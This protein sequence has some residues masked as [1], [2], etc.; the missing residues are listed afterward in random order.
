MKKLQRQEKDMQCSNCPDREVC[1]NFGS[2]SPSSRDYQQ[3]KQ[4]YL[5]TLRCR[6]QRF[7]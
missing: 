3:L 7:G 6:R 2:I 1:Y 4:A 5:R